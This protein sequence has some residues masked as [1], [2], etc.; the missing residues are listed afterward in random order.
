MSYSVSACRLTIALAL[1][2]VSMVFACYAIAV[3]MRTVGPDEF[4]MSLSFQYDPGRAIASFGLSLVGALGYAILLARILYQSDKVC[5]DRSLSR[6]KWAHRISLWCPIS[7]I[8]VA[9]CVSDYNLIVHCFFAASLFLSQ[10]I[11]FILLLVEDRRTL[12]EDWVPIV[13]FRLALVLIGFACMVGMGLGQ[14]FNL[15]VA[16]TCEIVFASLAILF[17][18]SYSYELSNCRLSIS[19]IKT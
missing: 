12:Y 11:V 3:P 6:L 9:A 13:K 17:L 16:S 10:G 2:Y 4:F 7:S 18:V 14:L 15:I 1:I 19:L 8:G 5:D